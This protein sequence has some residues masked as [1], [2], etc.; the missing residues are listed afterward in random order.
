MESGVNA[1]GQTTTDYSYQFSKRFLNDRV[2]V[3]IGGKVSSGTDATE[4]TQ[5][6][7][8]NIA[9]EYRLDAANNR[10]VRLFY[11]RNA[12]DPLEGTLMK[13]GAG[14]VMRRKSE[15]FGDLFIQRRKKKST[16]EKSNA[17]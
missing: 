8:D 4:A 3:V 13:T 9:I 14:F 2:R 17:K 5:S 16:T 7:I 10:Y 11:D 15:R 6:F 1:A 12:H